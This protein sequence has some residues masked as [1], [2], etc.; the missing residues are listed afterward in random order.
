MSAAAIIARMAAR[1]C[2]CMPERPRYA[3]VVGGWCAVS[4]AP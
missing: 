2:M 4:E 3:E 1:A